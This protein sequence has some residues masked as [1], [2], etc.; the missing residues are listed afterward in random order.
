MDIDSLRVKAICEEYSDFVKMDTRANRIDLRVDEKYF[1]ELHSRMDNYDFV[2]KSIQKRYEDNKT[3]VFA[4]FVLDRLSY[5]ELVDFITELGDDELK[6]F[7]KDE[8]ESAD[9]WKKSD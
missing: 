7:T 4:T 8:D 6:D 5:Q 1:S 9:W 2:C 3:I